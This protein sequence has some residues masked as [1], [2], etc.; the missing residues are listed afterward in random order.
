[1]VTMPELFIAR[2]TIRD[3]ER[4]DAE[5]AEYE[6]RSDAADLLEFQNGM[7]TYL[8]KQFRTAQGERR[9]RAA[10]VAIDDLLDVMRSRRPHGT[11]A[12]A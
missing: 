11:K 12:G 7:L 2:E 3:L 5:A 10:D 1:M 9:R 6:A 8:I 4:N